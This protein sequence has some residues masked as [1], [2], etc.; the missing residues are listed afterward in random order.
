[1]NIKRFTRHRLHEFLY[2]TSPVG[3]YVTEL[4][5]TY[6]LCTLLRFCVDADVFTGSRSYVNV[7]ASRAE[8]AT[9]N[10][11]IVSI[12]PALCFVFQRKR[13]E[14]QK[15]TLCYGVKAHKQFLS[16]QSCCVLSVLS[17]TIKIRTYLKLVTNHCLRSHGRCMQLHKVHMCVIIAVF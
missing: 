10:S 2:L 5:Y 9:P 12:I 16:M 6:L 17:R 4:R 7:I 15:S 13:I 1:V 8:I 3:H 11:D 14:V